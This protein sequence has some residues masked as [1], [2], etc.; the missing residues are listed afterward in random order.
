MEGFVVTCPLAPD[1]PH[2][3]SSFCSSPR[4]FGL[5]FLQT[6]PRDDALALLLAFGSANTWRGDFHPTSSVPCPA[7]TA[8]RISGWRTRELARGDGCPLQ[9]LDG[10]A[11]S[12]GP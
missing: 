8:L 3:V 5:G 1:V 7:H 2:L 10:L 9:P 4:A 12:A 11:R 6:P